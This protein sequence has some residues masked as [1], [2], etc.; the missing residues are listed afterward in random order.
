MTPAK[1][2]RGPWFF[3]TANPARKGIRTYIYIELMPVAPAPAPAP[4]PAH[5]VVQN[6]AAAGAEVIDDA[7]AAGEEIMDDVGESVV[8]VAM[9]DGAESDDAM[10]TT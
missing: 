4:E 7:D 6:A 1:R 5:Q 9:E 2:R 8:D 3:L 10:D